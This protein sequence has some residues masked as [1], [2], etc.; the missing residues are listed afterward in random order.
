MK[1]FFL[2]TLS[3]ILLASII[4]TSILLNNFFFYA[5]LVIIATLGIIELKRIKNKKI[6]IIILILFIIFIFSFYNLKTNTNGKFLLIWCL[7]ITWFTDTFAFIFGKI[8][9][10]KKI[11]II[12]PNKTYFGFFSGIILSQ[13]SFPIV[14]LFIFNKFFYDYIIIFT[15]QFFTSFLVI[16]GDL[17]FSYFKRKLNVK[18]YSDIIP[19]HGG[20]FDRIDGLIFSIIFFNLIFK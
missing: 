8:F 3:S 14:N 15:I 13:I 12:S 4:I 2:R 1:N 11:G 7:F 20:I 9:G 5:L 17:L 16:F 6:I 18:D 10:K 19:G